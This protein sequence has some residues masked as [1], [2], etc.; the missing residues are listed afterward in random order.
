MI[1][2]VDPLSLAEKF[3]ETQGKTG[4]ILITAPQLWSKSL[5][6]PIKRDI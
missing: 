5:V 2:D 6:T 1:P 4:T 3:F